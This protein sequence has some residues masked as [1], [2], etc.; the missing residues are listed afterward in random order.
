MEHLKN[1][2]RKLLRIRSSK[3]EYPRLPSAPDTDDEESA[4]SYAP[5]PPA[6][7]VLKRAMS[8]YHEPGREG[9]CKPDQCP[10]FRITK[11]PTPI[12]MDKRDWVVLLAWTSDEPESPLYVFFAETGFYWMLQGMTSDWDSIYTDFVVTTN[13]EG[14]PHGITVYFAFLVGEHCE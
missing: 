12:F 1:R 11:T 6:R 14:N 3:P 5:E 9:Q 7:S 10:T 4:S 2:T 13:D 8:D